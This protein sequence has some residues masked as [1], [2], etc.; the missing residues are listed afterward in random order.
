MAY[1]NAQQICAKSRNRSTKVTIQLLDTDYTVVDELQGDVISGNLQIKNS[2]ESNFSRRAGNMELQLTKSLSEPFY[3]IDSLHRIKILIT[4]ID[5]VTQINATYNMGIYLIKNS[6]KLKESN[7]GKIDIELLDLMSLYDGTFGGSIDKIAT[8]H[9]ISGTNIAGTI[10]AVATDLMGLSLDKTKIESTEYVTIEEIKTPPES[11]ITDHLKSIMDDTIN[12][13]LYFDEN[14]FLV[15]E[16]I[17]DR[18]TDQ[19]FQEFIDSDVVKKYEDDPDFSNVRNVIN[20]VGAM[21]NNDTVQQT[22]QYKETNKN[23]PFNIYSK[24]GEI[25]ITISFDKLQNADACNRQAE[26]EC[27]KRTNYKEKLTMEI[28]PDYM[29]QP[30]KKIRV[31][32]TA[33][34]ESII[35]EDGY[36]LIDDISCDLKSNGFMTL[37]CHKLYPTE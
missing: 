28:L 2:L 13:D 37:T 3:K 27:K 20:I 15:F 36:Y 9:V 25:P 8:A 14:G 11:N 31:K 33:E 5:N 22:G 16:Y 4:V 18:T 32:Y 1:T 6:K 26:Y 12:Y 24:Y 29:L 19:V 35:I 21:T 10:Q 7:N 34:D 23:N 30:N 17:K